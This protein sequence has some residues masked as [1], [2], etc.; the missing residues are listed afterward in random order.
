VVVA[1]GPGAWI[2]G[3][4]LEPECEVGDLILYDKSHSTIPVMI[5]GQTGYTL[6]PSD[7]LILG[8]DLADLIGETQRAAS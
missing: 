6:V 3:N 8:D 5:R 1:K 4:W 7:M 2:D